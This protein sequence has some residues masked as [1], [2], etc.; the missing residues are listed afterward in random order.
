MTPSTGP[1]SLHP[2]CFLLSQLDTKML[3]CELTAHLAL[4]PSAGNSAVCKEE[5]QV[6]TASP[7]LRAQRAVPALPSRMPSRGLHS[8]AL[9]QAPRQ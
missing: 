1:F 2:L 9:S 8:P 3:Y 6:R 4:G 7:P 5:P